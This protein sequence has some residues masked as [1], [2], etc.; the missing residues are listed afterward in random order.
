[1]QRAGAGG[2]GPDHGGDG[3][4]GLGQVLIARRGRLG[5]E[6]LISDGDDA[7]G[8]GS[9]RAE[10]GAHEGDHVHDH[11]L[12][13]QVGM[14]RGQH[15]AHGPAHGM[16]D[17]GRLVQALL[18]DV[19][20]DLLGHRGGDRSACIALGRGAGEA[21]NMD[22]VN[23]V[24]AV[25]VIDR[26]LPDGGRGAQAGDEDDVRPLTL[27]GDMDAVRGEGGVRMVVSG[28]VDVAVLG[29]DGLC[30]GQ[31]Q[32]GGPG[33]KDGGGA[34]HGV[35]SPKNLTQINSSSE[36]GNGLWTT[37]APCC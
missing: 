4:L 6:D 35:F 25:Q 17:D 30:G 14:P 24:G 8:R 5:G 34:D 32:G 15:H 12:A 18:A 21:L 33:S 13:D 2:F 1:M 7:L 19:A 9:G 23:A 37:G 29:Q 11:Q 27:D 28:V 26:S 16:A 36:E 10:H 22:A 20:G 3:G 31:Q